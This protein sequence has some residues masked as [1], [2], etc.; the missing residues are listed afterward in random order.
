MQYRLWHHGLILC[1]KGTLRFIRGRKVVLMYVKEGK[2]DLEI[3]DGVFYNPKMASLRNISVCLINAMRLSGKTAV[4]CT[5]ASGV[6]GIRYLLECGLSD[7]ICIDQSRRAYDSIMLNS[8]RNKVACKAVNASFQL[9]ANSPGEKFDIID[10]DPFGT[11][12]PYVYDAMKIAKPGTLMMVTATDT[13]VL[14]GA[15]KTACLR[16]YGADPMHN[17]L[18]HES[19]IRIL[20]AYVLRNAA[21]FGYWIEPVLSV[22]DM[23]Y[24]RVFLRLRRSAAKAASSIKAL[25]MVEH[26]SACPWFSIEGAKMNSRKNSSKCA[27]CGKGLKSYGPMWLG[28]IHN[29]EIVKD[30]LYG[31]GNSDV[32]D[33]HSSSLL[34]TI[35][36]ECDTPFFYSMPKITKYLRTGSVSRDSVLQIMEGKATGTSFDHFGIK[37]DAGMAKVITA[38]KTASKK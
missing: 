20:I 1:C 19:G 14:C 32:L 23:H 4:D 29:K 13:A 8:K 31:A 30:M 12:A 24:M 9:F 11:P 26:C 27:N 22:S 28:S 17:E 2:A 7:V 38:V 18:C 37:T 35:H 3:S 33:K 36:T 34:A 25:G 10:I 16:T 15:H 6:R 5:S 21:Q